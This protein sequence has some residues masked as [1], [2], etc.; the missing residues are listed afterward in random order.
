[1][2]SKE[3]VSLPCGVEPGTFVAPFATSGSSSGSNVFR[4]SLPRVRVS[5]PFTTSSHCLRGIQ[6]AIFCTLPVERRFCFT[7]S[8]VVS[9]SR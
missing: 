7:V 8:I 9:D 3:R 4:A 5:S 6:P 1:M 2:R